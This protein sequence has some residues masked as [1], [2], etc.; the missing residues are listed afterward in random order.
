MELRSWSQST[1][2][3]ALGGGAGKE[4]GVGPGNGVSSAV[5]GLDVCRLERVP[6]MHPLA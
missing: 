3:M 5:Q 4:L 1:G 2:P 6:G